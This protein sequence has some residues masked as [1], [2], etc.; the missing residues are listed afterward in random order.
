VEYEFYARVLETI[1][2]KDSNHTYEIELV[3]NPH[4]GERISVPLVAESSIGVLQT[5]EF[6]NLY[7]LDILYDPEA[8]T[9]IVTGATHLYVEPH[10]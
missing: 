5:T 10:P 6:G 9:Y 7:L 4:T 8:E 1:D 2:I 3:T